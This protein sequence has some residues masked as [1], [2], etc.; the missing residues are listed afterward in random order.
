MINQENLRVTC[1]LFAIC[2]LLPL[3]GLQAQ[4]VFKSADYQFEAISVVE[5]LNHPWAAEWLVDSEDQKRHTLVV[6]ERNGGLAF[7]PF[8][9]QKY[10][11]SYTLNPPTKIFQSGQ[12][13]L[14]DIKA[15][16]KYAQN[17]WIYLTFSAP[18]DNDDGATTV[19]A[20]FRISQKKIQDWQ[21]LFTASPAGDSTRH[22]GSRIV[23][24]N[25]GFVYISIGDRGE[26]KLAQSLRHHHGSIIR[27]KDDGSLPKDNP[28]QKNPAVYSYGHRN[29]Q[30]LWF[31][32]K[33]N[34]LWANEHGPRGGDE[35]NVI[36]KG[37]NYG[38]PIISYGNEYWSNLPVSDKTHQSGMQQPMHYW[39]PS[40]A[41]SGLIRYNGEE[42]AKWNEDFLIGSLKFGQL[43]R[44]RMARRTGH[45]F[46]FKVIQ[47][48]RLL[49]G[50][51]G[52]IRAVYQNS[53]KLFVLTDSSAGKLL[54]LIRK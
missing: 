34:R 50:K 48:E 2:V 19:L 54:Q 35:L 30:G 16:P 44:I 20:R 12:G 36:L 40:I 38:W 17:G 9:G 1:L 39:K 49:K 43:V 28:F 29:P 4:E 8:D 45:T 6:T 46:A 15:H 41:P 26:R 37:K 24:D 21:I 25:E 7:F 11:S 3:N 52:R 5:N 18:V 31:D 22:F 42:F 10:Q 51:L 32:K 14:L 47:E 23:F 53:G 27:L 13:G 33:N